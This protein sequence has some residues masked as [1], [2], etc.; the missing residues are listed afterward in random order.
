MKFCPN[1]E[2]NHRLALLK[3]EKSKP[4]VSKSETGKFS[5]SD[6]TFLINLVASGSTMK[7]TVGS[8][9]TA[10]TGATVYKNGELELIHTPEGY[11][12]PLDNGYRY[13]Y[14]LQDHLGNTRVSFAK[15]TATGSTTLIETND[16]YPFGLE[17]GKQ[18]SVYSSSNLGQRYKFNGV[19]L[20]ESTGLYEMD[21]RQFDPVLGRFTSIDPLAEE[22]QWVSTYNFGQNNPVL[23][24]DP[25]GLI[26][27]IY[28]KD[29]KKYV[30]EAD[31]T[32]SDDV[33]LP[34]NAEYVGLGKTDIDNHFEENNNWFTSTF[35]DPD[36]VVSSFKDYVGSEINQKI[37]NFIETGESQQLDDI[38]GLYE[39][40]WL[41]SP[42]TNKGLIDFELNVPLENEFFNG[43]II[44][45]K[46][47]LPL[48]ANKKNVISGSPDFEVSKWNGKFDPTRVQP[49][50]IKM[51]NPDITLWPVYIRINRNSG[52]TYNKLYDTWLSRRQ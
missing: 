34:D 45:V 18:T 21:F 37:G 31:V 7:K 17:H 48:V 36:V 3:Q 4:D 28:D 1:K 47:S 13:I 51:G 2:K 6:T 33:D 8:S 5:V 20:E 12:E 23:R 19:E 14:R 40:F 22:R 30:W 32:S 24:V 26:D 15:D 44:D 41:I 27:W 29:K 10:Y 11:V 52:D 42:S 35:G 38:R 9:V 43:G 25:T 50:T 39:N 16:Y 49:F 46:F